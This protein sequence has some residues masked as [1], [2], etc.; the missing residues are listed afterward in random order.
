MPLLA[1]LVMLM[2]NRMRDCGGDCD[3]CR[4]RRRRR[5][6]NFAYR[7]GHKHR[8]TDS[9]ATGQRSSDSGMDCLTLRIVLE[10]A[11]AHLYHEMDT[12]SAVFRC[13]M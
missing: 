7:E 3:G 9:R 5:R 10:I 2:G 11:L 6:R 8:D 13:D 1:L 4:R 12:F